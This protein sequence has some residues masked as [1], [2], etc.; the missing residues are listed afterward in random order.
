MS[1]RLWK[2]RAIAPYEARILRRVLEVGA[3]SPPS[4]AL[5]ASIEH[6]IVHEEGDGQA[7]HDSLDFDSPGQ[8]GIGQKPIAIA[9]GT[10]TNDSAIEL[11]VWAR[12]NTI[13]GLELEPFDATR[14]PIRMPILE[15]I[16]PHPGYGEP[17]DDEAIPDDSYI[18]S[19]DP[20]R[21][22]S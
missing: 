7:H 2:P 17:E 19:S 5:L 22:S 18:S 3:S 13:T 12:G 11:I 16:R 8:S 20:S 15:S 14:L 6:L 1:W 10:M 4:A 9:L 21:P